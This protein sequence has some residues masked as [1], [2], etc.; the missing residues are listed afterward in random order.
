M[1]IKESFSFQFSR[2]LGVFHAL[3]KAPNAYISIED[4]FNTLH[5][6]YAH[7]FAPR[8]A[9]QRDLIALNDVL[10]KGIVEKI[11]AVGRQSAS[12]R[13]S[14]DAQ[15]DLV[16]PNFIQNEIQSLAIVHSYNFLKKYFPESWQ[17]AL[18]D[19]FEQAQRTLALK[20]KD[21]WSSKFGFALDGAFQN[22]LTPSID[23]KE[24]IFKSIHDNNVWLEVLY[25]P[26]NYRKQPN[27]YVIKPHGI[28]IRGRKQ[29]LIASKIDE[30]NKVFTRTFTM[31]RILQAKETPERLSVCIHDIDMKKAIEENEYEGFFNNTDQPIKIELL[32]HIKI[33]TELQFSKIHETQ[34]LFATNPY[35]FTLIAELPIT[36]SFID[37][38]VQHA[39]TIE[40]LESEDL[41]D[42][43]RARICDMANNYNIDIIEFE[44]DFANYGRG[45]DDFIDED[46]AIQRLDIEELTVL[47]ENNITSEEFNTLLEQAIDFVKDKE[48]IS[49]QELSRYFKIN[50]SLSSR[51]IYKMGLENVI[52]LICEDNLHTYKVRL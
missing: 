49:E 8:K 31:H 24:K 37:W 33:L 32:C 4:L 2:V 7:F 27:V 21:I 52:E 11:P 9:L 1:S 42:E 14:A 30:N 50:Y 29:Y 12:F 46:G 22:Y 10:H 47:I 25:H 39:G 34:E 17:N 20:N 5:S 6:F 28:I 19:Q 15:L 18:S 13:L 41:R 35:H 43:V 16:K 26:E 3:P 38:L 48:Y 51:L 44:N 40:V 36:W 45:Y 23:I